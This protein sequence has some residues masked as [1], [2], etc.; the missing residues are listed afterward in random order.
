MGCEVGMALLRSFHSISV[1]LWSG[2]WLGHSK[3]RFFFFWSHSALPPSSCVSHFFY[4]SAGGQ[5]PCHYLDEYL[6][7]IGNLL[8]PWWQ[9]S[10]PNSVRMFHPPLAS[11]FDTG[12]L[13]PFCTIDAAESCSW[14]TFATTG[15]KTFLPVDLHN[16]KALWRST[17]LDHMNSEFFFLQG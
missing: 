14:T 9:K 3:G 4:M 7:K 2:L 11:C 10:S 13:W 12:K 17:N 15:Y 6:A 1:G 16:A 5:P 8:C